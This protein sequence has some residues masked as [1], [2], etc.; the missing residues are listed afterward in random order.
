MS[1]RVA[2]PQCN[3]LLSLPPSAAGQKVRC[4]R[5]KHLFV[6]P[7]VGPVTEEDVAAWLSEED[8]A[9]SSPAAQG[10][11]QAPAAAAATATQPPAKGPVATGTI[12]VVKADQG[13]VLLEF[14]ARRLRE[15]AFRCAM[16]RRC[17]RCGAQA[18]LEAHVIRYL[19]QAV[20]MSLKA[21]HDAGKLIVP[22]EDLRGLG[23]EEMLR[24]LPKIPNATPPVDLPM[25]YWLCDMCS[26]SGIIWG[27]VESNVATGRGR[28]RLWL[29][30]LRRAEQ[31]LAA[32]GG[33]KS[34][35]HQELVGLIEAA[36]EMPWDRLPTV[37]QDRI[38]QW[39]TPEGDE[40]FIAYVP[41]RDL[42][43]TEDGVAG[44]LV[45]NLE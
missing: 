12:R 40:A 35:G 5:C 36:A 29:Q 23:D 14:P 37:I 8:E 2:C 20:D 31:F 42:T 45:S 28:C 7:H 25:P 30:S 27:R 18:H 15:T 26:A 11:P 24:R 44:L 33:K 17:L 1:A 13:G 32:A 19:P 6:A 10:E 3:S 41:D 9:P 39:F 43:R 4:G 22:A 16:P 38:E 21:E 34:E